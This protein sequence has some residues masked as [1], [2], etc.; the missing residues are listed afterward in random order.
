MSSRFAAEVEASR[1]RIH[2]ATLHA[3]QYKRDKDGQ[4]ASTTGGGG[5]RDALAGH[6]TAEAVGGAAEAEAK[7]IT[8]RDIEFDL[9]GSDPQLAAEHAEGILRG[10]ER[11]PNT[12]LERV[13][14]GGN[15]YA[16]GEEAWAATSPSGRVITF[17]DDAQRYG[18]DSYRQ[19]LKDSKSERYLATGTPM[20]VALHEFGHAAANSYGLNGWA[21]GRAGDYAEIEMGMRNTQVGEAAGK[22][23][24][25]RAAENNHELSAEAFADVM[26]NGAKASGMSR[27]IVAKFDD[28]VRYA[29]RPAEEDA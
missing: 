15:A 13:Q 6:E 17:T 28:E 20:G 3:R 9:A 14:Q 10:L 12:P 24:S 29:D 7:R 1:A 2:T 5:V 23:I 27:D 22:A 8:G 21:N 19:D 26:V 4:F 18:A 16:E 25:R 11:Y